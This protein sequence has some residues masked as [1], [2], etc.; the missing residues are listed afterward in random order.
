MFS[1]V[2]SIGQSHQ[3]AIINRICDQTLQPWLIHV[4]QRAPNY[5]RWSLC[6][7]CF[8]LKDSTWCFNKWYH[9]SAC[10][11]FPVVFVFQSKC[12]L[13]SYMNYSY[14]LSYQWLI[15]F[16]CLAG[17]RRTLSRTRKGS[18]ILWMW[19]IFQNVS[20]D[21]KYWVKIL[22]VVCSLILSFWSNSVKQDW[23]LQTQINELFHRLN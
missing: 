11:Y 15:D 5:H 4:Q 2:V 18:N 8:A 12:H 1:C 20:T 17:L 13:N 7:S 19:Y 16:S 14:K 22:N 21:M 9:H 23:W 3:S 6:V 10:R